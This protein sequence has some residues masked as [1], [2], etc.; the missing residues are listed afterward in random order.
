MFFNIKYLKLKYFYFLFKIA[1]YKI[2]FGQKVKIN[3]L[4]L[5]FEKSCWLIIKDKGRVSF[6]KTNYFSRGS[7]IE[8]YSGVIT[9]GNNVF[10]N[11]NCSVVCRQNISFGNDVICGPN[12]NIYDHN[13]GIHVCEMSFGEQAYNSKSI[14]IGNNV[15]VGANSTIS[16]GVTINNN[17]I[18]AANSVV[19]KD[20]DSDSMYGGVPAKIIKRL[21]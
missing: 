17:V 16:S 19:T 3:N 15:W 11:K 8:V 4:K 20:L 5:G 1:Y 12:V 21:I 13:H 7:N 9:F 18:I 6:G 2:L 14:T 10:F